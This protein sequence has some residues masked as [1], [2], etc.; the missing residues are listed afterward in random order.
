MPTDTAKTDFLD[1]V[2]DSIATGTFLKLTLGKYRGEGGDRRCVASL[3]MLKEQPHVRFLTHRGTQDITENER[4]EAALERLSGMIGTDFLSAVLFTSR[5]DVGLSYS[6]KRV[7]RLTRGRPTL[8]E[9]PATTHDRE[10]SYLV[11]P[12]APYLMQLG[13][14]HSDGLIKPSMYAKF[15]Q[16]CRFVEIAD[17]LIAA[18]S[19][20]DAPAPHSLDVGA[21]KGYLTFALHEHLTRRLHKA[22]VTCGVETNPGLVETCN[23]IVS[24]CGMAGLT[25][26]ARRAEALS[27]SQLDVL[28]A[29]HACDTATDDA[30]HLGI[31]GGAEIIICAP[32]CQHEIAPQLETRA[33]PLAGLLKYGLLR[34]RQADLFTDAA[35]GLLLEAHGYEVRMIEFV[36]TE[37]T[38][39][40]LMIAAVRSALVD[41]ARA[42]RQY[43]ELATLAGFETQRLQQ[44]L[45]ADPEATI[46]PES[47]GPT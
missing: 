14:T 39:K 34:Q 44:R 37:H 25:F 40:N 42:A 10:K 35:R 46:S 33:T 8:A 28:I 26:E 47:A 15:R 30:I 9:A 3:V 2:R 18:S 1:A 43:A 24:R 27:G 31:T 7:G 5:E 11:D 36:S 19:L 21:G 16:I 13:V 17:Q 41:R 45:S 22:P 4:P 12:K 23:S 32:C 20:K 38:S 29:L 6:R